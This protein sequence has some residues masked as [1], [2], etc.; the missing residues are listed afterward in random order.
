M[1]QGTAPITDYEDNVSPFIPKPP[2]LN[3]IPY[4][5]SSPSL[6]IYKRG[7][8]KREKSNKEDLLFYRSPYHEKKYLCNLLI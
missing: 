8:I 7:K 5:K 1:S 6:R 2:L 3:H 4:N